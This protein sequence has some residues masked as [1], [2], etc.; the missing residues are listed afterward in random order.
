M[1]QMKVL[2]DCLNN[3]SIKKTFTELESELAELN[4]PSQLFV[5]LTE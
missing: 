4:M 3:V 1:R 5:A 2:P